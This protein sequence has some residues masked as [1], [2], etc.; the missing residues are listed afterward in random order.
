MMHTTTRPFSLV[1]H[2]PDGESRGKIFR[3]GDFFPMDPRPHQC[4]D[5]DAPATASR[6]WGLR[7]TQV[8]QISAGKHEGTS[9]S[10]TGGGDNKDPED[11]GTD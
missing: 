11:S 9:K 6:P 5:I 3:D 7:F 2:S 8:P 1:T 4:S 10:T